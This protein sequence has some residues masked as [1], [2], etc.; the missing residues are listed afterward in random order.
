M[1]GDPKNVLI[2]AAKGDSVRDG[3]N[4]GCGIQPLAN[5]CMAVG[6]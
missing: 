1:L 2:A 4:H 5:L 3:R 6:E